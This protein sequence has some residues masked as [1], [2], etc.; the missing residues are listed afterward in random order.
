ML[1]WPVDSSSIC[2]ESSTDVLEM[3]FEFAIVDFEVLGHGGI[4]A[5]GVL[6]IDKSGFC[7]IH[8]LVPSTDFAVVSSE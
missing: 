4:L 5:D 6:A 8:V 1:G 3:R 2:Y 7:V